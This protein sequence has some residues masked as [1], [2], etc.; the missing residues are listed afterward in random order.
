MGMVG[1]AAA[2][3]A[4]D[5]TSLIQQVE[6]HPTKHLS[7]LRLVQLLSQNKLNVGANPRPQFPIVKP[8]LRDLNFDSRG[9]NKDL[10]HDIR[11]IRINSDIGDDDPDVNILA[12]V[13]N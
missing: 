10:S 8:E 5:L 3:D 1:N 11:P 13:L 12:A 2:Y 7:E 4:S 9:S 6:S